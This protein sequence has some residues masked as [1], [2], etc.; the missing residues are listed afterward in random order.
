MFEAILLNE[1]LKQ[2]L[3]HVVVNHGVSGHLELIEVCWVGDYIS[4]HALVIYKMDLYLVVKLTSWTRKGI[5]LAL[6]LF[7]VFLPNMF[8]ARTFFEHGLVVLLRWNNVKLVSVD[9]AVPVILENQGLSLLSFE[10]VH[11]TKLF[12]TFYF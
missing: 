11:F 2:G 1:F 8:K 7:I 9:D 3:G 5:V 6:G 10:K 12:F 4:L